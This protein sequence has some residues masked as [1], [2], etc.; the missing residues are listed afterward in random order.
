MN[1]QDLA[2]FIKQ[3]S[4]MNIKS[5]IIEYSNYL[6]EWTKS[7]EPEENLLFLV[8]LSW[9]TFLDLHSRKGIFSPKAEWLVNLPEEQMK[10]LHFSFSSQVYSLNQDN[11]I[12]V[13][14]EHY[15]IGEESSR[16]PQVIKEIGYYMENKE[17]DG[18]FSFTSTYIWERRKDLQGYEFSAETLDQ[19]PF[20]DYEVNETGIVD[21]IVGIV[22]DIWHG[23][24]EESLNF[25]THITL[26]PDGNWGSF[27]K[28]GSWSG[29]VGGLLQ[30]RTQI[31]VS[32]LY[33]SQSRLQAITFSESWAK[34]FIR[35][36]VKYPE[37][38]ARWTTFL[39]TFHIEV[40]LCLA[41][42]VLLLMACL[43]ISHVFRPEKKDEEESFTISNT[44]LVVC[45][46][47]IGQGSFIDPK[48]ISA[49]IIIMTGLFLGII[50]LFSFSGSLSSR[51]AIFH[52][53][54]PF[55]TLDG[56]LESGFTIGGKRSAAE[57]N[58]FF[59]APPGS[60]RRRIAENLIEPHSPD[61]L[62]F[63][64]ALKKMLAGNYALMSNSADVA[65]VVEDACAFL[66]IPYD[67]ETYDIGFGFAKYSPYID[68]F[69]YF[70]KKNIENGNIDR[71]I[72]KWTK[73]NSG[74]CLAQK[75][76][77]SMGFD[78]VVSAF[79]MIIIGVA[80]TV[81]FFCAELYL[82]GKRKVKQNSRHYS[83]DTSAQN[84]A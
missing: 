72:I 5:S 79:F 36:F 60:I 3:Q 43:Y 58:S 73:S 48:P 34:A 65:Y 51:L 62:G 16:N 42:L 77:D 14:K 20:A 17:N 75:S 70:L 15:N 68:I 25:T 2:R 54:Y 33:K 28:D 59:N 57:L 32:S 41:M 83:T 6:T 44:S 46:T 40:W 26:P 10:D 39:E 21:H 13:L 81:V 45:G 82:G 23:I 71:I 19:T 64:N 67:I 38:D 80:I 12:T 53:T 47:L 61:N 7:K 49:R 18:W 9:K 29:M 55:K 35:F 66:E 63:L 52:V 27:E 76:L 11:S 4:K 84:K 30:N 50:T 37:R 31:V 24:L 78:N 1:K 22:G 74:E 69:N 8:F 56:V